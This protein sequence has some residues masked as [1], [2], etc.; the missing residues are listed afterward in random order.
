MKA[1]IQIIH[2]ARIAFKACK[3]I[4]ATFASNTTIIATF[5]ATNTITIQIIALFTFHTTINYK[6]IN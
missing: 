5:I 1:L 6:L 2:I 4:T 3:I